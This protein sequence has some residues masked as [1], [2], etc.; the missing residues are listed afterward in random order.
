MSFPWALYVYFIHPVLS[1]LFFTLLI[2]VI[3]SWLMAFR[4][5]NPYGPNMRQIMRM[6]EMLLEPLLRPIRRVIPPLGGQ[7]DLSVLILGLVILFARD[8]AIP[9]FIRALSALGA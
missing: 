9:E 8:W 1:F 4:V 2:W 6:L 5:L 3:L 7:L